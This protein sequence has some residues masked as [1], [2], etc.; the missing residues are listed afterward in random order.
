MSDIR[1]LLY[2][3]DPHQPKD[4][5]VS[6]RQGQKKALP[7]R[8]YAEVTVEA[9]E[10]G[11]L[12]LLDGKRARTPGRHLLALPT[13]GAAELVAAEWAAQVT[14]IDPADMHVTRIANVGID[15][16]DAVRDEILDEIVKYA[17]T[18]LVCYRADSPDALIARETA[19]WSPVLEHA[20]RHHDARFLI[21][22]GIGF[23][24]Q[25]PAALDAVRAAYARIRQPIGL[26]AAHTLVTLSGSALIPLAVLDGA[27]DAEAAFGAA[28]VEE[29][30][31][32]HLWGED[33]E[34]AFRRTRRWQ[35]FSAAAGLLKAVIP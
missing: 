2:P 27:M 18:D 21:A 15:R 9:G 32:T 33:E 31:N 8:F 35:E 4:A 22:E 17:G 28:S 13:R 29:D 19:Q 1:D 12:I 16:V 6:A 10:G 14:H 7:K 23:T 5:Y 20:R 24:M 30:W 25:P 26:A 11:Y 34:A 3:D